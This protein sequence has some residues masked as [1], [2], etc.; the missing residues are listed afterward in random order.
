MVGQ[1]QMWERF[2]RMH[3]KLRI[4]ESRALEFCEIPKEASYFISL[5]VNTLLEKEYKNRHS[6]S[7]KIWMIG[8]F[9]RY[10]ESFFW[11]FR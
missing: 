11:I 7:S 3:D 8:H 1:G 6:H 9:V 10:Q 4:P 2:V 5:D